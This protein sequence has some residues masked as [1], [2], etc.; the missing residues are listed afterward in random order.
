MFAIYHV[1][2]APLL[3]L[4]L[5]VP[6]LT[7]GASLLLYALV[8]VFGWAIPAWPNHVWFFNPLA[9][10]LLIVLGAWWIIEGKRLR[11]WVTSR[12][13]MVP[14]VLYLAFSLIIEHQVSGT[15]GPANSD[16]SAFPSGQIESLSI[17]TA[18]FSCSCDFGGKV[19]ASHLARANDACDARRDALWGELAANCLGVLLALASHVT[20]LDISDGLAMQIA[21]SLGEILVMII[22]AVLL[23]SI[24]VEPR[25][26]PQEDATD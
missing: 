23:N 20:L 6:N 5:R 4:L 16:K 18:A 25:W 22:A 3:W 17:T 24:R 10:Q 21:L 11:P 7:L 8:Y 13:L 2:F 14:A 9:W 12:T 26:Q 15:A 19:C 1:L